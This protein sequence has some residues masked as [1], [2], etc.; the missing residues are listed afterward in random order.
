MDVGHVGLNGATP[1]LTAGANMITSHN[2]IENVRQPT[3]ISQ[4]NYDCSIVQQQQQQQHLRQ[5]HQQQFGP[6]CSNSMSTST[7]SSKKQ[8]QHRQKGT[9][10]NKHSSIRAQQQPITQTPHMQISPQNQ[11]FPTQQQYETAIQL[12]RQPPTHVQHISPVSSGG[13]GS[14]S[15]N[16][17]HHNYKLINQQ[18]L[19]PMSPL[20]SPS[21]PTGAIH[22]N[23][24]VFFGFDKFAIKKIRYY[25][26]Q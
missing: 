12:Q 18:Q 10:S 11:N 24:Q 17:H 5:Q 7:S 13:S 19:S 9:N 20:S 15:S 21:A 1:L 22:A 6:I 8:N 2:L 23:S 25:N 14:G 3:I 16:V 26:Y 4:S